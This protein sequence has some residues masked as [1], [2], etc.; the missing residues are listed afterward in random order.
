M[1]KASS[2]TVRKIVLTHPRTGSEFAIDEAIYKPFK[3]AILESL[4]KSKGKS[5]TEVTDDV[6]KI[7]RKKMPSFK[8]SIPWY[9]IS[10]RL[11]LET[12]G[13]VET[14]IEKGKKLNRLKSH[15]LKG[16]R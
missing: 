8:K 14:F 1:A 12:R 13:I 7:I 6:V 4:S 9:T 11:D 5:F 16:S 15:P 2:T 3:A 10:I